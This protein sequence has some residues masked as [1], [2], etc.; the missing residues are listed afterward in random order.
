MP[1]AFPFTDLPA[2]TIPDDSF[3]A[4]VDRTEGVQP[5]RRAFHACSG[6]LLGLGPPALGLSRGTTVALLAGALAIAATLDGVRLRRPALN[7]RFFK[8]FRHLASPREAEGPASSTWYVL[9]ALLA[10]LLFPAPYASGA[11]LVLALADPAA[12][13]IGRIW[14]T[15]PVGKGSA[16]G[17]L[18]FAVVAWVSLTLLL[19][20]P[21]LMLAVAS[22][23][24]CAEVLPLRADDNLV[25]PLTTGGLLWL[26]L[27]TPVS[28]SSFLF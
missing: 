26:I 25:I 14:G 15:V 28:P 17:S 1:V 5:W 11:I 10:W 7:A 8:V 3:Q 27:G 9:G 13:L 2:M 12:S 21:V 6:L 18:A 23:V 24:A 4:L 19:G 22:L 16:Q 20:S